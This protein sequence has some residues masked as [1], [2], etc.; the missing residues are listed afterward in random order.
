MEAPP[1][2]RPVATRELSF[3]GNNAWASAAADWLETGKAAKTH[4]SACKP[5]RSCSTRMSAAPSA[6]ASRRSA[7]RPARSPSGTQMSAPQVYKAIT[8][9]W[10]SCRAGALPSATVTS[11]TITATARSTMCSTGSRRCWRSTSCAC[12]RGCSSGPLPIAWVTAIAAD[13]RDAE[14]RLRPRQQSD[15]SG[16]TAE[17]FGEALDARRRPPPRRRRQLTSMPL[18][19]PSA[20]PVRADRRCR[21][22]L[23]IAEACGHHMIG[24][25][26]GGPGDVD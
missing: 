10:P 24:A 25:A 8:A 17:V 15:G 14:D 5:S 11:A 13:R 6:T 3:E 12:C 16:Q 26:G 23:S 9:I 7:A 19:R 22:A 4:A 2:P 1:A 20:V 18:S 21:T